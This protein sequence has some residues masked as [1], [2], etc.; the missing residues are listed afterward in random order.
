MP[1]ERL[2]YF[3]TLGINPTDNVD[4][5]K[6]AYRKMAFKYHPDKNNS[7]DAHQK[8]LLITEAYEVLT[9]Q[10]KPQTAK[11][12]RQK[13]DEEMLAEKIAFAKARFKYQQEEEERKDAAYYAMITGGWKWKW[14]KTGA[15]YAFV[16]SVMLTI[17][18][19]ATSEFET[20]PEYE[21]SRVRH[22]HFI[23]AYHE[24]FSIEEP[25]YWQNDYY[26]QVCGHRS[27]LFH[28]LKAVSVILNPPEIDPDNHADRM[29]QLD[30]FDQYELFTVK[31]YDSMYGTFP[32]VQFF[33]CVPLLLVIYKRPV[34]RFSIW[35]LVSIYILYPL[36]IFIL[37]SNDRLLHLLGIF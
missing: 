29:K 35:R 17:D 31:S 20:I 19:F 27:F 23:S 25:R 5:I 2:R 22:F 30:S 4:A 11:P 14:F 3:K 36:A 6:K 37:I 18:F 9:G 15:W 33:L 32:L 10:R 28:D 13:S 8:F 24:K 16:V 26:G 7:A 21:L 12:V 34:L 1:D